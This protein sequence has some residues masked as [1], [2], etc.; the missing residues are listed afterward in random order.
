EQNKVMLDGVDVNDQQSPEPLGSVLP[1]PLNSGQEFRVTTGGG[2]PDVGRSSDGQVSLVTKSGTIEPHGRL[3][4]FNRN[5]E[6]EANTF[7]NNQAGVEREK[8]I[9]NQY[10]FSVG[11]PIVKNRAFFFVNYEGRRDAR[12][13]NQLRTVPTPS[14]KQGLLTVEANDGNQYQ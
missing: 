7:F 3:Y 5:K 8:L 13:A 12:S 1:V 9:R 4:E 2:N 10:G 14:L 11:G 6:T